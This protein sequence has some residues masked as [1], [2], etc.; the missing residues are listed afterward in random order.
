MD[1]GEESRSKFIITD[2][3]AAELLEPEEEVF[4]KMAFFIE[5][6]IGIPRIGFTI[7]GWDAEIRVVVSNKLS[8]RP[9]AI[10]LV[11][12]DGSPFQGNS[13]KQFPSD[14]D[15]VNIASG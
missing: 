6:P 9:F 13:V 2:G 1:E 14:G 8:Q 3:N 12:K 7:P 5:P 15:I 4:H 10:G 11:S